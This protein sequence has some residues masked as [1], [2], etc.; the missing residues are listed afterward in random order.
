MNTGEARELGQRVVSLI[1]A[2]RVAQAYVLLSPVVAARTP[3]PLLGIVG[4]V[5]GTGPLEKV[6]ALLDYIAAEEVWA[7]G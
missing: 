4:E 1:E 3:F 2:G 7:V 5:T 6:N